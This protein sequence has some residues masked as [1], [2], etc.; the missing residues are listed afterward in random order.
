[1]TMEKSFVSAYDAANLTVKVN[2]DHI[3]GFSEDMVEYEKDEENWT[4]KVG[5]Q[6]DVVRSRVNNPLA[7]LTITL[8]A[9]SPSV[10][11]LDKYVNT[12]E[13]VSV[14]VIYK[15]QT[16]LKEP[17]ESITASKAFIKKAATRTYNNE[18]ADRVYELQLLDATLA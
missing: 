7:T 9:A 3:T 5:A 14:S 6:G 10:P 12:T 8:L 13:M 18:V 1:M 2:N 17:D 11:L 4:T 16:G 15:G